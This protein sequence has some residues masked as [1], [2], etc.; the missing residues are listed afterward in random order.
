MLRVEQDAASLEPRHVQFC[1]RRGNQKMEKERRRRRVFS[2][3]TNHFDTTG[4]LI[5][6]I[7][8]VTSFLFFFSSFNDLL[9]V[10]ESLPELHRF[11]FKMTRPAVKISLSPPRKRDSV[12][13]APRPVPPR[14]NEP[15]PWRFTLFGAGSELR[16]A[17]AGI[18]CI[19]KQG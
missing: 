3:N 10:P 18:L 9:L 12:S 4:L 11:S 1:L 5:F 19:Y 17:H 16:S 8:R 15:Q 6:G 2:S 13:A 7:S 14:G